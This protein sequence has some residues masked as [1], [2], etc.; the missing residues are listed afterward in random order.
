MKLIYPFNYGSDDYN[1]DNDNNVH[2]QDSGVLK[3]TLNIIETKK[4]NKAE[5]DNSLARLRELEGLSR[6]P[7][8]NSQYYLSIHKHLFQD[9][10]PWAGETRA[11]DIAK[12]GS[13]FVPHQHI[14]KE[15]NNSLNTLENNLKSI[16]NQTDL[17]NSLGKFL[18]DV[19]SIHPFPEGNGRTQRLFTNEV[20]KEYGYKIEWNGVSN[21]KM[22]EV[23]IQAHTGNYIPIIKLIDRQLR[24]LDHNLE[25]KLSEEQKVA[26]QSCRNV[27][28][29]RYKNNPELLAQQHEAL[30][31]KIP[32]MVANNQKLP[33]QTHKVQPD[34]EIK[35]QDRGNPDRG[36]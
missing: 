19:N 11:I 16:S 23:S 3:N 20:A 12:G 31:A 27:I 18:G 13:V 36:K 28:D 5:R 4:L 34:V 32:G 30:N 33:Q 6:N 2:Y 21:E 25:N 17:A 26:L 15:L 29:E 14:I 7:K 24:E 9:I 10:Y 35:T 22:K 8:F 1:L